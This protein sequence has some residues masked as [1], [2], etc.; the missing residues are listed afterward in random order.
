M[1]KKK[2]HYDLEKFKRSKYGITTTALK[3]AF[4]LGYGRSEVNKIIK[5]ME[6]KHFY[7]SMTSK[8]D[9]SSWQDVYHVP[10]EESGIILYFKF[11]DDILCEFK[12]L[13]F[14]EK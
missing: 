2:P 10:D 14:K 6:R 1:E 13:S 11:T 3:D 5:S 7:K 12:V 8:S 4:S 9:C